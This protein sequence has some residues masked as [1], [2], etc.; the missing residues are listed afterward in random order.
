M[1]SSEIRQAAEAR[2][3]S[4]TKPP[5][6]LG[7][8]EEII[9]RLAVQQGKARP[10][11]RRK[12]LYV[13]CG[14]HG[15]TTEG[16]SAYPSEVTRQMVLNFV[17]G[18]AAINVLCRRIGIRT[19]IVDA[20][21]KGEPVAGAL[22]HR[23]GEGTRNF[24][25]EPAMTREE[26]ERAIK[27]GA[28]LAVAGD[29]DDIRAVGEMGIGNTTPASALLCVFTDASPAEAAG[30][31]TGLAAA[32]VARKVEVIE[33]ALALHRP[34]AGDP[35]GVLAQLGGFEIAMMA[36]FLLGSAERGIPVMMDGFISCSA[37][38]VACRIEPCVA[39]HLLYSH[40]SAEPAH[41]RMLVE[42]KATPLLD[43]AMRLGEGSGAALGISLLEH[44]LALYDEMATFEQASVSTG[45]RPA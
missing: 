27:T 36:G 4:L 31:G 2:W 24:L 20:G 9:T 42:L 11:L 14:D 45:E 23:I 5:G 39:N 32:G 1:K 15:V 30:P 41:A 43:L 35:V 28:E 10:Q 7:R 19:V 12:S 6:S 26:A 22:A 16:V 34:D 17:A 38:L 29:A 3:N 21:V 44:A 33:R 25:R 18:G 8:L 13:F 40:R 37:A